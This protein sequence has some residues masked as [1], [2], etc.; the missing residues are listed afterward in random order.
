M[1]APGIGQGGHQEVVGMNDVKF[2]P[3]SDHPVIGRAKI[4]ASLSAQKNVAH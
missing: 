2:A 4:S 1:R 3:E